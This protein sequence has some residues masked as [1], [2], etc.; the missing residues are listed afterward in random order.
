[1]LVHC[2]APFDVDRTID[3]RLRG[4]VPGN[5]SHRHQGRARSRGWLGRQLHRLAVSA[6][7]RACNHADESSARRQL[8]F[9]MWWLALSLWLICIIEVSSFERR[10]TDSVAGPRLGLGRRT[11]V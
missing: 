7:R 3:Q 6:G 4:S 5:L 1:M 11:L 2:R 8:A 10:N 9:D